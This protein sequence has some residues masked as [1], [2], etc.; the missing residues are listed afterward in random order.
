M[1]FASAAAAQTDPVVGTYWNPPITFQGTPLPGSWR[2][3][4]TIPSVS[5]NATGFT[6]F[7]IMIALPAVNASLQSN[8]GCLFIVRRDTA[9]YSY[10][11]SAVTQ[12]Q[13]NT[14]LITPN[15]AGN[16]YPFQGVTGST[17]PLPSLSAVQA[18]A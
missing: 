12:A 8:S 2:G 17:A 9:V 18:V 3:D 6:G 15:F 10:V 16:S 13:L 4:I 14:A 11:S 1:V 7:A 5:V